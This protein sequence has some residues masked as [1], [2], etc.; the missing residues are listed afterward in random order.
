[1]LSDLRALRTADGIRIHAEGADSR[2][3]C[4]KFGVCS[5]V[6]EREKCCLR[7]CLCTLHPK[8][9]RELC[10]GRLQIDFNG[11]VR[12]LAPEMQIKARPW[13]TLKSEKKEIS[14]ILVLNIKQLGLKLSILLAELFF[15][16]SLLACTKTFASLVCR[17]VGLFTRR[18]IPETRTTMHMLKDLPE[19]NALL[20]G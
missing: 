1:M 11:I 5:T 2:R 20:V 7:S 4:Y 3:F 16:A 10:K 14:L 8:R 13:F 15:L 9:H 12:I 6:P 19:R 17:V 18:E